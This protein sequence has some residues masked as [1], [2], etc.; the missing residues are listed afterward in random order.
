MSLGFLAAYLFQVPF[1]QRALVFLSTIP[2]TIV[3]NSLRIGIVGVLVDHFGPQD[4]DGFLHMF[5]GWIIFIACAG[6]LVAEMTLLARLTLGRGFFEVFYPPKVK[7]SLP[8]GQGAQSLSRFPLVS[9]LLL[10]CA[11]GLATFFVS[12]RHEILPER[13]PFATFPTSIGEWQ[14]RRSSMEQQVEQG[15]GL[16]DYILSDFA[17]KDGR[18]VNL[19][20]AY[21]ASQRNGLSPHSPSVCIPGNGWQITDIERT[22]YTNNDASV[23]LPLNRVV[24]GRGSDKQLVYYWFEQRGMKIA[25]EYLSKLYLLRDAMFKN[26]TDGALVRLTTPLYPGESESDADKRLQDFTQVVVPNLM[27]YLPSEVPSKIKPAMN[28]LNANHS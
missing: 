28:S 8:Q 13:T 22:S 12:A 6:V 27:G 25:N 16:T 10:L 1:W 15:L 14:G 18:Q 17:K 19:Y 24:I 5:E 9:C 21:Y 20:V 23:S 11:A 2:I 4:A 26:R 3:M 7:A